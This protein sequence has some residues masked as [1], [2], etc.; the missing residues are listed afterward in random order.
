MLL[1]SFSVHIVFITKDHGFDEKV[2]TYISQHISAA[3]TDIMTFISFL[4]KHSFLIPAY[5]LLLAWFYL[6]KNK[7][8]S[9]RV[10]AL[11]LGSL[12]L[13]LFLKHTIQRARP[14]NPLLEHVS[15]YSFPSGHALMSVVFYGILIYII[16]QE[17]RKCW[18]KWSIIILLLSLILLIG[19]SRI[20][21]RVHYTT[22]VMAGLSIG[23]IWLVL[24]LW[25]IKKMETREALS[26]NKI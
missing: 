23:Y 6:R 25:L 24:S 9:V 14:D 15:G 13:M 16:W 17:L 10:L 12:L 5:L 11:S 26:K 21:L 4:G 2:F 19:F 8:H 7:W 3:H 18:L 22:D 20:Y 1:L